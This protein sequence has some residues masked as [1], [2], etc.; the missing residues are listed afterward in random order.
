MLSKPIQAYGFNMSP[1]I[2]LLE[3]E[4]FEDDILLRRGPLSP[5][6]LEPLGITSCPNLRH[7]E[8]DFSPLSMLE[9]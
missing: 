9:N 6:D 4:Y 3:T 8:E 2:P 1:K 7:I 5:D